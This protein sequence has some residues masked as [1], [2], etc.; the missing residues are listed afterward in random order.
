M[1]RPWVSLL[2]L[3]LASRLRATSESHL[4][5]HPANGIGNPL[6]LSTPELKAALKQSA[7]QSPT[8][9]GASGHAVILTNCDFRCFDALFDPF[10]S[11][12]ANSSG[13]GFT[14]HVS[15]TAAWVRAPRRT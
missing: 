11:A 12:I 9:E 10:M 4:S 3:I 8:L 7:M 15:M 1:T 2:F 13:G 14:Q 5:R 6:C